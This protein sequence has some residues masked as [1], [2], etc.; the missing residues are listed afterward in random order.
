M[1]CGPCCL[2]VESSGY[3]V[4]VEYF[5]G[6]IEVGTM[7]A[8][9]GGWIHGGDGDASAGDELV[10]EGRTGGDGVGVGGEAGGEAV[11]VA[12]MSRLESSA[13]RREPTPLRAAMNVHR[14]AGRSKGRSEVVRR[15]GDWAMR[16]WS[17][18]RTRSSSADTQL[19][20]RGA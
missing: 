17:S 14:R 10:L 7:A 6:E 20:A 12:L 8:L 11:D 15:W 1:G 9:E 13:S 3:A 19:T 2:E 5:A 16:R 4:D 18:W